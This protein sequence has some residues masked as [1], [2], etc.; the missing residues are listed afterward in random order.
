MDGAVDE[1][2]AGVAGEAD[3]EAG[4]VALVAGLAADDAGGA[5]V[6][7]G[8]FA[9]GF[10]VW[11]CWVV[12]PGGGRAFVS[13]VDYDVSSLFLLAGLP[14]VVPWVPMERQM[15]ELRNKTSTK[16]QKAED[17]N[18]RRRRTHNLNTGTQ[19]L[20]AQHVQ[21]AIN[22]LNGLLRMHRR[23]RRYHHRLQSLRGPTFRPNQNK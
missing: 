22:S 4:L 14:L 11:D 17:R 18:R 2:A 5:D 23:Q 9:V 16:Q 15:T 6:A 20:L 12:C 19:R 21:I 1:D 7:G 3:E 8:G 10:L 13:R